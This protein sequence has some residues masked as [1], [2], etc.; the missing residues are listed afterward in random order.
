MK[1]SLSILISTVLLLVLLGTVSSYNDDRPIYKWSPLW[2]NRYF[3]TASMIKRADIEEAQVATE[4]VT[5]GRRCSY[6]GM[7]LPCC[8]T[9]ACLMGHCVPLQDQ[10]LFRPEEE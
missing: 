8:G 6:W 1:P 7:R 4:C 9:G 10:Y 2:F 5:T 3:R